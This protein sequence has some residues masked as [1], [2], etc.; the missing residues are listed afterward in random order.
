MDEHLIGQ[1]DRQLLKVVNEY[2]LD[3]PVVLIEGPRSVGKSTLIRE[4]AEKYHAVVLDFDDPHIRNL[5][6]SDP[7]L[8]LQG[9]NPVFIDEYQ[10]APII[11]DHIKSSLNRLTRPGRFVL[12]GSTRHDAL[13]Q[14]AQALTGRLSRL[15]LFPF[16][17]AELNG[18]EPQLIRGLFEDPRAVVTLPQQVPTT[19]VEY[20]KKVLAGGFP[21]ALTRSTESARGRWIDQYL[22]L[23]LSRDIRELSKIRQDAQLPKLLYRLAAQTAQ[24]LSVQ[25]VSK[26]LALNRSTV[27]NYIQLLEAVFLIHRLPAWGQSPK[28]RAIGTPKLHV[29]DSA[30][31]ARLMRLNSARLAELNTTSLQQFGHVLESFVVAEALKQASWLP[32]AVTAG[33]WRTRDGDEVDLIL[34]RDDGLVVALEVKSSGQVSDSDFRSL[35]K[36]RRIIG[37]DFVAGA[38]LYLG[39]QAFTKE[40]RLHALPIDRFWS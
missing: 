7:N 33:H 14:A 12:T 34:E 16:A 4:L 24:L 36:L 32:E 15:A 28:V 17:Q 5:V 39:E 20:Q 37:T 26:D 19:R 30:V 27:E 13:P 21:L 29:L 1:L 31:A 25:S 40:D 22:N 6:L 23:T 9:Q 38:I 8:F 10:K 35:R 18:V 3:D 11:L 2:L